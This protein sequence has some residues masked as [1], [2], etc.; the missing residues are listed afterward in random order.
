MIPKSVPGDNVFFGRYTALSF[1]NLC[2]IPSIMAFSPVPFPSRPMYRSFFLCHFV[3]VPPIRHFLQ[4]RP[5]PA[6]LTFARAFPLLFP[7]IVRHH[8]VILRNS[9]QNLLVGGE[10][11]CLVKR[12]CFSHF[13]WLKTSPIDDESTALSPPTAQQISP[14]KMH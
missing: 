7:S 2:L 12:K 4:C 5:P 10:Q 6:C 14:Q 13:K 1:A 3:Y 9:R 11:N 8:F